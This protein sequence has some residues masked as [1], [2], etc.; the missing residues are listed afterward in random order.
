MNKLFIILWI[1]TLIVQTVSLQLRLSIFGGT[2]W[3]ATV[4]YASAPEIAG[5]IAILALLCAAFCGLWAISFACIGKRFRIDAAKMQRI[6]ATSWVVI[7]AADLAFRHKV[8][9]FLG[10]AF[11]FFE[12]ATGVGGVLHM[13]RQALSWYGDVILVAI[14]AIAALGAVCALIFKAVFKPQNNAAASKIPKS[15]AIAATAAAIAGSLLF[16]S[17]LTPA[18]PDTRKLLADETFMGSAIA[19]LV[20]FA[21][22]VDRDGCGAFDLPPDAA[23]FDAD[24]HPHAVDIPDDGI[25]QDALLGDLRIADVP[26]AARRRIEAMGLPNDMSYA[27]RK[28]VIIAVMESVRHDMLDARIGNQTVM[29][30]LNRFVEDGAKRIDAAF[31]TRGFTQN[32]VTQTFWGSYFDPGHSLV[33]DFKELGY[34]TAAYSGEDLL[35]EG[36]DESLGWNRAGDR[37]VDPRSI[38]A[39]VYHKTSIPA[40]MLM[41]EVEPFLAQYDKQKPL[42]LYV[43]FQDPHFPYQQDNPDIFIDRPIKRSE[44]V[45]SRRPR[46]LRSYANQ[47][48]HLDKAA[49][50]LIQAL[51]TYDF[52]DDSIVIFISDH[53]ESLFDDGYLLGHGIA[54]SDIMTHCVMAVSGLQTAPPPILSHVD[55]RRLIWNDFKGIDAPQSA[56]HPVIQF[57]GATTVPAAISYRY[58]DGRRFTYDFRT[59]TASQSHPLASFDGEIAKK[60]IA[61]PPCGEAAPYAPCAQNKDEENVKK[62]RNNDAFD[63]QNIADGADPFADIGEIIDPETALRPSNERPAPIPDPLGHPRIQNLIRSWEYLRWYHQ[64]D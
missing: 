36:F 46:L 40:R 25:D 49:G 47:V 6:C 63:A 12:F 48:H 8:S 55:L 26:P 39:N 56:E 53:G 9:A 22:D 60:T 20:R 45:A 43:F 4:K 41:D 2:G 44:I 64:K 15:A 32:S 34:C 37:V 3:L 28:H 17:V 24:I 61:L 27:A 57:I 35:D 11:S 54:V 13:I 5:F 50:R 21:T 59:Q 19:S 42:F 51:K 1:F 31:A 58:A 7:V 23:P 52:F 33:D 62:N 38:P 29:P 30:N 10:S 14:L 18:F 16:M